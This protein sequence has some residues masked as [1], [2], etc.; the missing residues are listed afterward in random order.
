MIPSVKKQ[1]PDVVF[2]FG[3]PGAVFAMHINM[4]R[5]PLD[6]LRVRQAIAHAIDVTVWQ[7]AFGDFVQPMYGVSPVGFYGALDKEDVR[8][9][10]RI[11]TTRNSAASCLPRPASRMD[12]RSTCSSANARNTRPTC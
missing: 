11:P 4:T 2:D 8:R 6:D 3:R 12:F 10:G 1:K 9:T 7:G 5:K